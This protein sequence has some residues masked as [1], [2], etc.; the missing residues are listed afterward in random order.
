MT[1]PRQSPASPDGKTLVAGTAFIGTRDS[2][3]ALA[4]YHLN[5]NLDATF[6]T[7]GKVTTDF[8]GGFDLMEE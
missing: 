7:G 5:G 6:G 3:F 4:R 1:L 8:S 2:A